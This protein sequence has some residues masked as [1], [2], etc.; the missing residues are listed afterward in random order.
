MASVS[1]PSPAEHEVIMTKF[2]E[3]M[4][5]RQLEIFNILTRFREAGIPIEDAFWQGVSAAQAKIS[6]GEDYTVCTDTA[7]L[8]YTLS[9]R[10]WY[11]PYAD[12]YY[13]ILREN[14]NGWDQRVGVHNVC[15]ATGYRMFRLDG[16]FFLV[17]VNKDDEI[18]LVEGDHWINTEIGI[19][20]ASHHTETPA[21]EA[22]AAGGAGHA[23][24]SSD[25]GG[26]PAP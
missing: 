6:I 26:K 8:H 23:D 2:K 21:T 15:S 18:N 11:N 4:R 12:A 3:D 24:S 14:R 22:S 19:D 25:I 9:R 13:T 17:Y 5:H 20:V 1:W 16:V 7:G 10:S